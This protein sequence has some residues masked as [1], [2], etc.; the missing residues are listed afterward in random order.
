MEFDFKDFCF[1]LKGLTEAE[2]SQEIEKKR[3]RIANARSSRTHSKIEDILAQE[4]DDQLKKLYRKIH[5]GSSEIFRLYEV[6]KRD[7]QLSSDLTFEASLITY[8]AKQA[9]R[10]KP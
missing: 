3:Q 5:A 10:A 8:E 1:G 2:A 7:V 6:L 4:W 9:F